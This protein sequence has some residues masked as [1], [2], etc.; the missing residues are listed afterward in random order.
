MI[1]RFQTLKAKSNILTEQKKLVRKE[2]I[3]ITQKINIFE[4]IL[5][6]E[7]HAQVKKIK[8]FLEDAERAQVVACKLA[9]KRGEED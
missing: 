4:K 9:K 7:K 1:K 5:L 3:K 6:P 8:I 2:A